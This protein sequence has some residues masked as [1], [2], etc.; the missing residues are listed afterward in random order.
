MGIP[1]LTLSGRSFASRV[2]GSL[3]RSAG[4]PELICSSADE[5]VGRAIAFGTEPSLLLP[6]RERLR[7][8]RDSCTLFDT[9]SLVLHLEQLYRHMWQQFEK[10]TLPRPDL[11]NLDVYWEVGNQVDHEELEVQSIADYQGWWLERLAKRNS[12]RPV[13][14]DR[15]LARGMPFGALDKL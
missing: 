10:G 7:A 13:A 1:V 9:P 8:S 12:F 2:C 15:R 11:A 5:F 14:P 3:V 4:I 6:F